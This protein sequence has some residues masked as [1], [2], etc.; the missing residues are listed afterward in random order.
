MPKNDCNGKVKRVHLADV[1]RGGVHLL[2]DENKSKSAGHVFKAPHM[3]C[4][5]MSSG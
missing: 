3:V 4:A 1:L 2:R 5:G